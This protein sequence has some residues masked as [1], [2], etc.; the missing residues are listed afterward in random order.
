MNQVIFTSSTR[1]FFYN[2]YLDLFY[3][4][5]TL[6]LPIFFIFPSFKQSHS[7]CS[8]YI[9]CQFITVFHCF[10]QYFRV[11]NTVFQSFQK[12][13][14]FSIGIHHFNRSSTVF[15]VFHCYAS[16]LLSANAES[17]SVSSMWKLFKPIFQ[18]FSPVLPLF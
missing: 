17:F 6:N 8:F 14:P 10:S 16:V 11:L 2:C 12:F 5:V 3:R 18:S 4:V 9:I 1:K 15:T 13:S 7:V